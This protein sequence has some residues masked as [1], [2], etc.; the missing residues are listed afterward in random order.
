MKP[1]GSG[2][3]DTENAPSRILGGRQRPYRCALRREGAVGD[4]SITEARRDFRAAPSTGALYAMTVI[5]VD[6]P[7]VFEY[8]PRRH[9]LRH[10]LAA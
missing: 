7:G 6:A 4:E 3:H 9:E 2:A 10:V 8:R 1:A 5:L